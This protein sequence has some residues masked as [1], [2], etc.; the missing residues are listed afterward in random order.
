MTSLRP[1]VTFSCLSLPD[2]GIA[3]GRPRSSHGGP[4]CGRNPSSPGQTR[5]LEIFSPLDLPIGLH[6]FS[7]L[8]LIF[9]FFSFEIRRLRRWH[10]TEWIAYAYQFQSAHTTVAVGD[11]CDMFG[12]AFVYH[13][14][15]N[16]WHIQ[17]NTNKNEK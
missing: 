17:F 3:V 9:L 14:V 10:L 15:P 16:W 5:Y 8:L 4:C 11:E 6:Y 13:L 7:V 2:K 1:N 12:R